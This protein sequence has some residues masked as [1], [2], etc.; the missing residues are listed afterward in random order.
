M[1]RANFI[2]L[3][4]SAIEKT[5]VKASVKEKRSKYLN[6][7]SNLRASVS[8]EPLLANG[9]YFHAQDTTLYDSVIVEL[10]RISSL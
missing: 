10:H 1:R 6:Q 3:K 9:L 7:N 2:V 4:A 5:N 8:V